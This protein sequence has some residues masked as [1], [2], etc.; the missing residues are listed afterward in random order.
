LV[1]S[2]FDFG[3]ECAKYFTHNDKSEIFGSFTSK[4]KRTTNQPK[5]KL[6]KQNYNLEMPP[7]LNGI[8]N[9]KWQTRIDLLKRAT[10][11]CVPVRCSFKSKGSTKFEFY[12]GYF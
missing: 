4:V 10:N 3:G 7:N 1:G 11:W 6:F 8:H 5:N 2:S 9:I 12:L